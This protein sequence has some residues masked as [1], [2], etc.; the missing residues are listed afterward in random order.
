MNRPCFLETFLCVRPTFVFD[1]CEA[2]LNHEKYRRVCC[3]DLQQTT[4][5]RFCSLSLGTDERSQAVAYP[6]Y[7]VE[8][9]EHKKKRKKHEKKQFDETYPG[10][11]RFQFGTRFWFGPLKRRFDGSLKL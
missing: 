3:V 11:N 6:Q 10:P 8:R 7:V 4:S 9:G 2:G 5:G 1:C